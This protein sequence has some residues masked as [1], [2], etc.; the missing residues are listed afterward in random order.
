MAAGGG[1][2]KSHRPSET[3]R[4]LAEKLGINVD[5]RFSKGEE[6]ALATTVSAVQGVVLVCW[7]HEDIVAIARVLAPDASTIPNHWPGD[8]FNVIFKFE[9][10]DGASSW[11]FGQTSLI[12]LAGDT[13]LPI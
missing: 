6:A 2:S 12:M 3:V 4:F 11:T 7:Q 10:P 5:E 8:R 1:G 13:S 9:K